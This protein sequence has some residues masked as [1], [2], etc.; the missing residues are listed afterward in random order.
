MQQQWGCRKTLC[1][2][3]QTNNEDHANNAKPISIK[4]NRRQ[5]ERKRMTAHDDN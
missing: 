5:N 2:N 1:K 4:R 3:E